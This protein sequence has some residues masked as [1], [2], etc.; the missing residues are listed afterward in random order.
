MHTFTHVPEKYQE[1]VRKY[2][3][4]NDLHGA[5]ML[6][7]DENVG[8]VL[9]KLDKM[10]IAD[11]T[12]VIYSSDN[13]PEHVT[14][15][16]G[17]TTPFRGEK[18]TTWEGGVRVPMLVRWPAKIKAG[19]ELNGLQS[20]EDVFTTLAAAAGI[21]DIRERIAK[22]DDLGTGTVKKNYIDGAN[23]LDYWTGKTDKSARDEYLYY[24]ES[25][26]QA[27]RVN[28][29][30]MHF[31]TRNGY[32][33]TTTKLELPY[34]YNV[35]QDPFES[36]SQFPMLNNNMFQHKTYMFNAALERI[37]THLK[38]LQKYPPKQKAGTLSIGEMVKGVV[39]SMP[40]D[41]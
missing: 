27:I 29:W 25:N 3:S 9:D 21:T 22:G 33:G 17:A 16:H 34:I 8:M 18:M 30:K 1:M 36:Y 40:N 7:H 20:H 10:G 26:L 6:Q 2:T 5:G 35:R 37:M 28:Q 14:Y 23:N 31:Y 11:N 12:I 13:G 38:T 15:P 41:K 19:G 4:Y 39:N 24:A 32:Y